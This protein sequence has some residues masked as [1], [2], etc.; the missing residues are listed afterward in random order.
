MKIINE[1]FRQKKLMNLLEDT[2]EVTSVIF[3]DDIIDLVDKK[4]FKE[5][6]QLTGKNLKLKDLISSL[7]NMEP[8]NEVQNIF[9]SIGKN[10]KF[11]NDELIDILAFR[12]KNV[13]PNAKINVVK[14]ILADQDISNVSDVG[15]PTESKVKN[16]YDEFKNN[17]ISVVG[18]YN[19]LQGGTKQ[20]KQKIDSLENEI[21]Q[22]LFKDTDSN[23]FED[24]EVSKPNVDIPGTDETDFDTIYE[25]LD[26]FERIA[27]SDNEYKKNMNTGFRPDIEQIQIALKFLDQN[28]SDLEVTGS[29]D[30]S[31]EE[32]I[33]DFQRNNGLEVT[34]VADKETLDE[35][36]FDLRAKGFDEMDLSKY[37]K[38]ISDESY[39][40]TSSDTPSTIEPDKK[41]IE[42][43][44]KVGALTGSLVGGAY[45]ANKLVDSSVNVRKYPSNIVDQ[46]KKIP[47]V[48]F[49]KFKS[50]VESIGIPV[51][52][53]IRQLY[54]ESAFS[55]DIMGCKRRSSA[56]AMGIAQFMPVT[57]PSY[58][59]GG[60]PCKVSDALPA[61]VKLMSELVNKFNG[62]LD[63]AMAGYNGGPNRSAL[64]D[65]V[66]NNTPFTELKGK[67]PEESYKYSL[68]ILQP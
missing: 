20:Q 64:R 24:V 43:A 54:T 48:D 29:Y 13:F 10:D 53:A 9:F 58:G 45:V 31:T 2:R 1:I 30:L 18:N 21:F 41:S 11:E 60:D 5:L 52:I 59:K 50:D 68:S 40:K 16:F 65:A 44:S 17:G 66:K 62:R 34:G 63:L 61:Y 38:S 42:K 55:P 19:I 25:F 15:L 26:R 32:A 27:K 39:I 57:W 14:P 49:N 6:P 67:I 4:N 23:D 8:N 51:D 37:I 22:K 35:M 28:N 7:K 56:G 12:L 46:F 36:L 3:G 47:G 33:E